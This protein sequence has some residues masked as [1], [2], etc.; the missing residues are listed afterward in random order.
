MPGVVGQLL[1]GFLKILLGVFGVQLH[2][3]GCSETVS[4]Q[5][6]R[7]KVEKNSSTPGSGE[8]GSNYVLLVLGLLW[9]L[10][11]KGGLQIVV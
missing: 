11:P 6:E 2:P 5:K 7:T 9:Q 10:G 8:L 1:K 4:V 3:R